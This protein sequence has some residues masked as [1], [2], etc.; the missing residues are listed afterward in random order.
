MSAVLTA[1]K[2]L[3][4]VLDKGL[5]VRIPGHFDADALRRLLDAIRHR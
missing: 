2:P 3:E 5:L 1:P 4:L